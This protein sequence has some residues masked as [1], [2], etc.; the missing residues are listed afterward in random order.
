MA[1]GYFLF[2]E[3]LELPNGYD[4]LAAIG[5]GGS[6]IAL[7]ARVGGGISKEK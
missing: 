5:L 3:V 7:F 1:L 6:S 4:V 2:I